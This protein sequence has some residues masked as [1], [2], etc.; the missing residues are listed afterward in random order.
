MDTCDYL[1]TV[2]TPAPSSRGEAWLA[3]EASVLSS[4]RSLLPVRVHRKRFDAVL[5]GSKRWWLYALDTRPNRGEILV[6]TFSGEEV[7]VPI[8]TY[9]DER[10]KKGVWSYYQINPQFSDLHARQ[11]KLHRE[12][13]LSWGGILGKGE[14]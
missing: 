5:N 11:I 7:W 10:W 12:G 4:Y 2:K 3:W 8:L 13:N 14:V 1:G 9:R 6:K